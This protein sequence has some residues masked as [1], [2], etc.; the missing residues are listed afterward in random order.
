[1]K[2]Y[3][4]SHFSNK[5]RSL[6]CNFIATD[7][8]NPLLISDS[9]LL[10]ICDGSTHIHLTNNNEEGFILYS[11][12]GLPTGNPKVKE[13]E[14]LCSTILTPIHGQ[15]LQFDLISLGDT[16]HINHKSQRCLESGSLHFTA[17]PMTSPALIP[18]SNI[19]TTGNLT[20]TLC[21]DSA[22]TQD[23]VLLSKSPFSNVTVSLKPKDINTTGQ[24]FL[25]HYKGNYFLFIRF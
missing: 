16:D 7:L 13:T 24:V 14:K 9:Q 22:P 3:F 2:K 15:S 23:N 11:G 17:E 4:T 5:Y 6:E 1:M 19:H 12:Q 18:Q 21:T 25:T 20:L 8:I 10:D